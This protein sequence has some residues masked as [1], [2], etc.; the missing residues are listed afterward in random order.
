MKKLLALL[1]LTSAMFAQSSPETNTVC[2][3]WDLNPTNENVVMYRVYHAVN[4]TN[5]W[6]VVAATNRPPVTIPARAGTNYWRCTA[7]N[8]VG[9]ESDPSNTVSVQ[10]PGLV[11]GLRIVVT[12]EVGR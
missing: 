3:T 7:V 12:L 11:N 6:A 4:Q 2:L 8:A 9:L 5:Q 10:P 1:L